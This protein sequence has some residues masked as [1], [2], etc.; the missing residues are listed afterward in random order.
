M[1]QESGAWLSAGD[2]PLSVRVRPSSLERDCDRRPTSAGE[3][4]LVNAHA[5]S[6][7]PGAS[8]DPPVRS[9]GPGRSLPGRDA[10]HP[11]HGAGSHGELPGSRRDRC[12]SGN[13][14]GSLTAF[15]RTDR[16]VRDYAIE[17]GHRPGG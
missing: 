1:E 9:Q 2:G 15:S 4:C 11:L 17:Y 3:R 13:R 10:G 12:G 7:D 16:T 6:L 8:A 14:P 5:K